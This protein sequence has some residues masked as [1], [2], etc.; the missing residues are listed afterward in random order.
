MDSRSRV[1]TRAALLAW[2]PA[3]AALP[4]DEATSLGDALKQSRLIADFNY[5]H[6]SVD[7]DAFASSSDATTLRSVLGFETA[8]YRGWTV[9]V[10]A[11]DV[12]VVGA[13]DYANGGFGDA[14]NGVVGQPVIGDPEGTDLH[15]AYLKW[16]GEKLSA[17]VGR[18]EILVGDQ[19]FVGNVGWRQHRQT[20][21]AATVRYAFS[22]RWRAAYSF[23]ESVQRINRA[24]D[25]IDGHLASVEG[26]FGAGGKLLVHAES[27]DYETPARR[28][29]SSTT[30]GVEWSG[31]RAVG[32]GKLLWEL[33]AAR[34]RDAG[35]NPS[36][37]DAGYAFVSL[38]WSRGDWTA[39]AGWE[40][41]DGDAGDGQFNTPLATLHKF[42]GWA[43]KFLA[44][45]TNGL[46][47]LYL[48]IDG[49]RGAWSWTAAWHDFAA[50]TGSLDYGTELDLQL[51]WK[52]KQGLALGAKAALYDADR[53][54][55][56]TE[57][58]W[59][60]ASYAL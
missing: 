40:R 55:T 31:A 5:R 23:L 46:I 50:A 3:A 38:G 18:D 58:L 32:A 30:F 53:L 8:T 9:R 49:K 57:K 26:D 2:L 54:S 15:R 24:T 36:E 12:S 35:D 21:D 25:E 51:L 19:R 37:L 56:D 13:D 11:E 27:L 6:E 22:P 33:E 39:R 47:D 45:P 7:D 17:Q 44:T 59:L 34:Q 1:L 29:L 41:L 14:S 60:W 43:D 42:N 10:E 20:F 28:G 4:A 48:Q 16:Q 52:S